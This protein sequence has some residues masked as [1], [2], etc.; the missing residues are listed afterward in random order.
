[1]LPRK[2][3][4]IKLKTVSFLY[5]ESDKRVVMVDREPRLTIQPK[6]QLPPLGLAELKDHVGRL[7]VK[8]QRLL[9]Q[10]TLVVVEE[11]QLLRIIRESHRPFHNRD[12]V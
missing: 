1:M 2:R 12:E 11:I 10:Q 4:S 9:R 7:T 6:H 5:S 8:E 3:S